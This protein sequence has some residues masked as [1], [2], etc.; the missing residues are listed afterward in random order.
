M[1]LLGNR[2]LRRAGALDGELTADDK[3][4]LLAFLKSYGSL[5]SDYTYT[6]TE[7]RGYSVDP[8]AAGTPGVQLGDVPSL[9]E[10]FASNVGRYFSFEFGYEQAMLTFQPVGGMDAIPM[11]F[12]KAIG[13]D[14]IL[15]GA[16]VTD[17]RNTSDGVEVTYTRNGGTK[18][19]KA[20]Y[21]IA[22]LAPWIFGRGG[23]GP[24]RHASG[25]PLRRGL[26]RLDRA[27]G[28][29]AGVRA[30]AKAPADGPTT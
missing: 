6:G 29:R 21:C 24:G 23:Q 15:T 2:L 8:S 26:R 14:K 28:M 3:E 16:A 19:V 11:A 13:P 1:R 7:H 17:V 20:D 25:A 12:A 4:R 5:G 27:G 9:S 18:V 10:V 30:C 22:T